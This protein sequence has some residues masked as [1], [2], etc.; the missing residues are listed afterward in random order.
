MRSH[1][2]SSRQCHPIMTVVSIGTVNQSSLSIANPRALTPRVDGNVQA[3]DDLCTTYRDCSQKGVSYKKILRATLSQP[4]II[5]RNDR[6]LFENHYFAAYDASFTADPDIRQ[7]LKNRGMPAT[8]IDSWEI[9][10][11]DP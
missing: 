1:G 6:D 3:D 11:I 5:D 8:N 2:N 9:S 7:F 10:G 4:Q